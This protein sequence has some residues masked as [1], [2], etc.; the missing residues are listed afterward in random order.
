MNTADVKRNN[1]LRVFRVIYK[2]RVT[3]KLHIA[4]ALGIS[5]PTVTQC[6]NEL[7]KEGL[8]RDDHRYNSAVGRKAAAIMSVPNC[9]VAMGVEL[10]PHYVRLVTVNIY[11]EILT[12]TSMNMTY[13][14]GEAYYALLG[15]AINN[16]FISCNLTK[17]IFLGV[18]I[19]VQGLPNREGDKMIF[20][21]LMKNRE[22]SLEALKTY[23]HF[24]CTLRHDAEASA[25]FTLW[26]YPELRDFIYL[27][28]DINLGS[29]V[30]I[31][32]APHWGRVFPSGL[33]EHIVVEPEGKLCYCGKRGCAERYCSSVALL[34]DTGET[35]DTF[36]AKLRAGNEEYRT[37]WN[38]FLQYLASLIGNLQMVLSID[39]VIGGRM[40]AY[41]TQEDLNRLYS[42]MEDS[43]YDTPDMRPQIMISHYND[44]A[45]GAALYYIS[46]FIDHPICYNDEE[47]PALCAAAGQQV[48]NIAEE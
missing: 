27:G 39:T 18:G 40:A 24:A 46:N 31:D 4:Q 23:V 34:E 42:L 22:F 43:I 26:N 21:K 28:M 35:L 41:F 37:R 5:L 44:N 33:I 30:I 36:F 17:D 47:Q 25:A 1:T 48:V 16:F 6:V 14:P 32:R 19:A 45:A 13:A 9:R 2:E 7:K 20:G 8:V 11:N 10:H 29:A 15:S 12:E 3:S 38:T